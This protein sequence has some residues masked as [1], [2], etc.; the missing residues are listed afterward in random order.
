ML[1]GMDRIKDG[2]VQFAQRPFCGWKNHEHR[3]TITSATNT[4]IGIFPRLYRPA[5]CAPT[6]GGSLVPQGMDGRRGNDFARIVPYPAGASS[7]PFTCPPTHVMPG[8]AA[9]TTLVATCHP[10]QY[11]GEDV[12]PRP[13]LMVSGQVVPLRAQKWR[14]RGRILASV[15]KPSG[16]WSHCRQGRQAPARRSCGRGW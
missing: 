16:W 11:P 6:G 5:S 12:H 10:H 1:A 15:G 13:Q 7:R 4:G 8:W 3:A 2:P 9:R 14:R